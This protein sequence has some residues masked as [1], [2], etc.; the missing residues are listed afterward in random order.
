M[1]QQRAVTVNRLKALA[2]GLLNLKPALWL[3]G[4]KRADEPALQMLLQN[5]IDEPGEPY[6]VMSSILYP[7]NDVG[8]DEQKPF[9]NEVLPKV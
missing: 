4:N 3:K 6:A 9:Y 5:P 1:R 8:A 2:P 7:D